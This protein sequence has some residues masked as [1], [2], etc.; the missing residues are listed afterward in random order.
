MTDLTLMTSVSDPSSVL[1]SLALLSY[2][3]RVLPVDA[4]SMIKMP[5][6]TILF[7]DARDDMATAKTLCSLIRTS[8]LR[9]PIILVINE[10]G[11]T[12]VNTQWG[13]SDVIVS[14][15]SPAEVEGRIRLV[16]ERDVMQPTIP[17]NTALPESNMQATNERIHSGDLMVDLEGYTATLCGKPIDLAYKEFELLKYL[18][19]HPGR[20]FTRT[21]LL[22]EVWGYDY[23]GGTRTVDVHIRRL[24]AKLGSEYEQ[25]IG[26]V[27]NVGYRFNEQ[28]DEEDNSSSD[29][30]EDENNTK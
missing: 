27:R 3:I 29:H 10:G 16:A 17:D 22:Q 9:T 21:Q 2:R 23:Y 25:L 15:A 11:F 13:I 8:G 6:H 24:R 19:Q 4:A 12:V 7:M 26:T 1:P 14:S 30:N 5:E 18:V 20:V 28:S